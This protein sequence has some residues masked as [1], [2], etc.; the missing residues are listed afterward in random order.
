MGA[1]NQEQEKSKAAREAA[2][3]QVKSVEQTVDMD[4]QRALMEEYEKMYDL[5]GTSPTSDEDFGL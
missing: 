4:A 5:G 3:A 2:R 1:G